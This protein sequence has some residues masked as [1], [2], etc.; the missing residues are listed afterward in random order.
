MP[1]G[2]EPVAAKVFDAPLTAIPAAR[3]TDAFRKSLLSFM[4]SL[5]P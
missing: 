4:S 1:L 5:H 3:A 2:Y